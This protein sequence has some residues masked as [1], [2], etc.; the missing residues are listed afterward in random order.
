MLASP[1]SASLNLRLSS[2][3]RQSAL[4]H[5]CDAAHRHPDQYRIFTNIL[6]EL[7]M[8]HATCPVWG[9]CRAAAAI[10]GGTMRHSIKAFIFAPAFVFAAACSKDQPVDT[11][12]S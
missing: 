5:A 1:T 3:T 6:H 4:R 12:L 11:S 7:G 9:T 2:I 8:W 10:P